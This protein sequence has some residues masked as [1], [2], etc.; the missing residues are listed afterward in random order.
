MNGESVFPSEHDGSGLVAIRGCPG[1]LLCIFL[2]GLTGNHCSC[3]DS[4]Q[5]QLT[6]TNLMN[7][8]SSI[9]RLKIRLQRFSGYRTTFGTPPPLNHLH[10]GILRN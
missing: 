6:C 5:V 8:V 1:I 10:R 2:S 9:I 7:M 3:L 4:E